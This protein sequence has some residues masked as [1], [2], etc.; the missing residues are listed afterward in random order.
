MSK[1]IGWGI[2]GPG[3]IANSFAR[4]LN[5]VDSGELVA[6][7]SRSLEKAEAF[8]KEYGARFTYGSY[9]ELF[10]N[11]EVHVVY[12]AIPHTLHA[13]ISIRAMEHGKH[14]LCEKPMGVN[15]AEVEAMIL[16]AREHNV[17]LMEALWSRFNPSIK[18]IK[19]LADSGAIGEIRYIKADF[20]FFA[21]DR[22][23]KGRLLN[24]QLAGGSLLDIG[25]YPVFLSYLLLGKPEKILATSHVNPDG[26]ELQTSMIFRYHESHALL[27]SGL[28]SASEMKAEISG[29]RGS[30]LIPP[31][32]H[33]AQGFKLISDGQ[34]QDFELK[35]KGKGYTYEIEEVHRC[36]REE[37][38]E[39]PTWSLQNSVDLITLLDEVRKQGEVVFPFE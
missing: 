32:W 15:L 37:K 22:D 5:L 14:V 21:L 6:V 12:I 27:F 17:F 13:E 24:A 11:P 8:A 25:I 23:P 28:T 30:I 36:L 38:I 39:S 33:E 16:A 4:D 1:K 31:R 35:T 3:K 18:K 7:A 9:D 34:E 26:V 19:D 20:A 2:V 10:Q 29:T